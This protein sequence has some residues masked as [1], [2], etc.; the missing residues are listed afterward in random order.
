M[1][2]RDRA[3]L[4]V[5]YG[6]ACTGKST[7]ALHFAQE[8]GI[9]TIIHTDYVR[10]VQRALAAPSKASPLMKVTHN[11][12][13]LFGE[14]SNENIVRGFT[15]HVNAVLPALLA[16]ACKLSRD[17]LDAIIEGVHCHGDAI[18]RF[19]QIGGLTV[20]PRLLVVTSESR[21]LDHIRHKEEERSHASEP[22]TW[23]DHIKTLMAIQSFLLQ[24]AVQHNIQVIDVDEFQSSNWGKKSNSP[25]CAP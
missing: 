2:T 9:R 5:F 16:V 19:A 6:V 24:D 14:R 7:K 23:E 10:E 18:D 13:E 22:K 21:L 12:W 25:G 17:G 4:H 1:G 20:L 8:H 15:A 3:M 11:A